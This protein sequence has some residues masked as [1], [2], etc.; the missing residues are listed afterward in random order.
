MNS[1]GSNNVS[2]EYE[3]YATSG[4][5]DLGIIKL[6]FVGKTQ[7][8][9]SRV[10]NLNIANDYFILDN[11]INFSER[12]RSGLVIN[13]FQNYPWSSLFL[14]YNI[15]TILIQIYRRIYV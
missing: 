13:H 1:G 15:N 5:W 6:A 2:L 3:R 14:H 9:W 4:C 8:L 7:F 11:S 10:F 12:F